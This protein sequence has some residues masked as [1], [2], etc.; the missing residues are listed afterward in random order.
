MRVAV[1]VVWRP[2]G[3]TGW[4]GRDSEP[5][6]SVPRGLSF[7]RSCAP[8]TGVHLASLLPRHWEIELV[9][10]TIRDVDLEMDVDAVGWSFFQ[11][12][13]WWRR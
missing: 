3:V 6:L 2:K 13:I 5:G 4:D 11:I 12:G 10:E 8:Y 1:V 7:D 9:H